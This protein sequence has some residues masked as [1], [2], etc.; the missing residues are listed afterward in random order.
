MKGFIVPDGFVGFCPNGERVLLPV[1][2]EIY[3]LEE[4]ESEED[5]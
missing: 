3:E 4:D 5:E 2:D 1:E